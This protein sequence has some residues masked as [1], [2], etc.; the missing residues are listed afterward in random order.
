[1]SWPEKLGVDCSCYWPDDL[2]FMSEA[3]AR[4]A[5]KLQS[6]VTGEP[7]P[8]IF[9]LSMTDNIA[10]ANLEGASKLPI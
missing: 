9:S 4:V 8:V 1:M 6:D 5:R 10:L 7:K 2:Q 3:V